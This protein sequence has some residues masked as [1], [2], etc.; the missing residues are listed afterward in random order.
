MPPEDQKL[1][2][3]INTERQVASNVALGTQAL[4]YNSCSFYCLPLS[5]VFQVHALALFHGIYAASFLL[6]FFSS[7]HESCVGAEERS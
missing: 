6:L 7:L 1:T 2:H 3:K 4:S 5:S